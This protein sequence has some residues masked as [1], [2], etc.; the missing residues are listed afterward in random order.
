MTIAKNATV[1]RTDGLTKELLLQAITAK[2][3]SNCA[4]TDAES[5]GF[6]PIAKGSDQ[7]LYSVGDIHGF[8]L[9]HDVKILPGAVVK[10]AARQRADEIE[11]EQGRKVGR[12]ELAE[13]KE[14]IYLQLLQVAFVKITHIRGW[15]DAVGNLLVIDASSPTKVDMVLHHLMKGMPESADGKI[16]LSKL[17]DTCGAGECFNRWIAISEAPD[18]FSLDDRATFSDHKGG[19]A[20]ITNTSVLEAEVKKL[21]EGRY[22]TELA[23]THNGKISF[24]LTDRL[25]LKSISLVGIDQEQALNQGDMLAEELAAAEL[26]V[27]AGLI[28]GAAQAIVAVMA[29]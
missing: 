17:N 15:Y 7:M 3:F 22:C 24:T 23:L 11:E 8:T 18:N 20:T 2:P 6:V 12:K 13:I 19:K 21:S 28:R 9:R 25:I 29:G 26:T 5:S 4:P 10:E 27:T 16:V 14:T 1:F